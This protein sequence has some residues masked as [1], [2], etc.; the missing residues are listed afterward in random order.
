MRLLEV[1]ALVDLPGG[2]ARVVHDLVE[3][4]S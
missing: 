2:T 3:L 1:C 4:E